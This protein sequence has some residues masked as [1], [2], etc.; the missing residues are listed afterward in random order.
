MKKEDILKI[1][2]GFIIAG[3]I[4]VAKKLLEKWLSKQNHNNILII[5]P[6]GKDI[7]KRIYDTVEKLAV[8]K[9]CKIE[10]IEPSE[11]E[12]FI[13]KM[14]ITGKRKTC[15]IQYWE[16]DK[17]KYDYE[18]NKFKDFTII[19]AIFDWNKVEADETYFNDVRDYLYPT[20]TNDLLKNGTLTKILCYHDGTME[21]LKYKVG[22]KFKSAEA[23][24]AINEKIND[25]IF[26]N[27]LDIEKK[28]QQILINKYLDDGK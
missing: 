27:K 5:E 4:W 21:G 24:N 23:D 16:Y 9:N 19:F 12:C 3:L 8:E 28:V 7:P 25:C 10:K 2:T 13:E 15:D 18:R 20:V 14:I 22:N 17:N 1:I 6:Q 11:D 26:I